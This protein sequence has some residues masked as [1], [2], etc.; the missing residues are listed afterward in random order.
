MLTVRRNNKPRARFF[1]TIHATRS[2]FDCCITQ[3]LKRLY[4]LICLACIIYTFNSTQTQNAE[5]RWH[6]LL[7]QGFRNETDSLKQ[8]QAG[9]IQRQ[10]LHPNL[11]KILTKSKYLLKWG[12]LSGHPSLNEKN[13]TLAEIPACFHSVVMIAGYRR[14]DKPTVIA[15]NAPRPTSENTA[16]SSEK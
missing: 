10:F 8:M 6:S 9:C 1:K 13:R 3:N 5:S 16:R 4:A 2:L 12:I 15:P 14:T 7:F 11:M